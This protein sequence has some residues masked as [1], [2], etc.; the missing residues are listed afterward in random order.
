MPSRC[1]Y[2]NDVIFL[3]YSHINTKCDIY[4]ALMPFINEIL[5]L[6]TLTITK[7]YYNFEIYPHHPKT[8]F[9]DILKTSIDM[10]AVT[11]IVANASK[12]GKLYSINMGFVK[13]SLYALFTF[14]IPNLFMLNVLDIS[15]NHITRFIIGLI[16]IYLLDLSVNYLSCMYIDLYEKKKVFN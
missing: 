8:M 16:F 15:K 12:Y 11:G 2:K 5:N 4:A 3:G 10:L 1:N 14:L 6:V 7:P 9:Q 13:G